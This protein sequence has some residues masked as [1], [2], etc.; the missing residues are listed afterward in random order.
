MFHYFEDINY[1]QYP[2]HNFR[3]NPISNTP[4]N[5]QKGC[6]IYYVG[7]QLQGEGI[8]YYDDTN[9]IKIS[10]TDSI[11]I[12]QRNHIEVTLFDFF[13]IHMNN[14]EPGLF[15]L[16]NDFKT[17]YF[18]NSQS[19]DSD[20]TEKMFFLATDTNKVSNTI[21]SLDY[22]Q[23]IIRYDLLYDI[24]N[25]P[26]GKITYRHDTIK[27]IST[28]YDWRNVKFR[29]WNKG[30]ELTNKFT[31][32]INTGNDYEDYLTFSNFNDPMN[33]SNI[34]IGKANMDN[35]IIF[36]FD[37]N[38]ITYPSTDIII[39]DN[40]HDNTINCLNFNTNYIGRN[41]INNYI[42]K[43]FLK[44][45]I[46]DDF[47]NN[48]IKDDFQNNK[49]EFNFSNNNI[50]NSFKRNVI[51][52]DCQY[53]TINDNF[54]KNKIG[55]ECSNNIFASRFINNIIADEFQNNKF[56]VDSQNNKFLMSGIK[57]VDFKKKVNNKIDLGYSDIE[58]EKEVLGTTLDITN[59]WWA[60]IIY[61]T[62]SDSIV[63]TILYISYSIPIQITPN[64]NCFV[65][66]NS[67]PVPEALNGDIIMPTRTLRLK[68]STGD[69]VIFKK[70]KL[71]R[72]VQIGG[73]DYDVRL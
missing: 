55:N 29:R 57:N 44:N 35:N 16:I 48:V 52:D 66:F 65:T 37:D 21:W 19:Y 3:L 72:L 9:W 40:S 11:Y 62:N 60:G 63:D 4:L 46:K 42:G 39:G 58:I 38:Y 17:N 53:N 15:Y 5:P 13:N 30:N 24:I 56:S 25:Y 27:N 61:I 23:D 33:F 49:I 26:N 51:D 31:S 18:I 28:W 70:D 36:L 68:G 50:G 12:N 7:I 69:N 1:N 59:E 6:I 8:Y 73:N 20:T 2:I 41:F 34:T 14:L 54:E 67:T 64:P 71:G 43:N 45:T 32:I 10:N 22:P 47:N